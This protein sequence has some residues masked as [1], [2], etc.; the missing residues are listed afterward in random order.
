MLGDLLTH[1][2]TSVL[3]QNQEPAWY[4]PARRRDNVQ[5]PDVTLSGSSAP[6]PY[7]KAI[8]GTRTFPMTAV[9]L[10]RVDESVRPRSHSGL[11]IGC[12]WP[13]TWSTK[14]TQPSCVALASSVKVPTPDSG[15]CGASPRRAAA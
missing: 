5:N 9:L 13:A 10:P 3:M 2:R 1:Q 14:S 11:H 8:L 12:R 7:V 6:S 15:V 4:V